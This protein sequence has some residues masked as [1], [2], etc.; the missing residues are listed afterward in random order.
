MPTLRVWK[1]SETGTDVV[2]AVLLESD[3]GTRS[4][5]VHVALAK[6]ASAAQVQAAILQARNDIAADPVGGVEDI[7]RTIVGRINSGDIP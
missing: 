1:L 7:A 5:A 6:T 4:Q 3:D 2:L